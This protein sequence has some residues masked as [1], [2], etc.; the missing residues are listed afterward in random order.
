MPLASMVGCNRR[1]S[2]RTAFI[3]DSITQGIGTPVN[4]YLHWNALL[5]ESFGG[6]NA[7][8]NLGIG[9]GRA[10]DLATNGAWLYKA[11]QNDVVVVC[12]GVNDIL[13]NG[14]QKQLI[15]D[16]D[17]IVDLLISNKIKVILQTIPPF[18]YVGEKL[19]I[20]QMAN[21]H[22]K[23]NLSE[24][25]YCVFDVVP[26]L[27]QSGDCPQKAKYGLHPNV[28]GCKIWAQ[29]LSQVFAKINNKNE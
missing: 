14:N 7:Y 6:A 22:I 28:E 2:G 8:W 26:Y 20:W 4:S 24:K 16:F 9:F 13:Q 3:G 18:D 12:C 1:I 21:K 15:Q 19:T 10:R 29:S 11:K 23:E 5:S 27:S 25:V 17:T